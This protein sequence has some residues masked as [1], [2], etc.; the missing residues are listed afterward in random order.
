MFSYS[1]I[2]NGF[3]SGL[4]LAVLTTSSAAAEKES[5][6]N[7]CEWGCQGW[8][9]PS[10]DEIFSRSVV[11]SPTLHYS[12]SVNFKENN[13]SYTI[14]VNLPGIEKKYISITL[15]NNVLVIAAQRQETEETKDKTAHKTQRSYSFYRQSIVLPENAN[16]HKIEATH[17]NGVV[18]ITIPKT[19]KKTAKKILIH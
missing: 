12:S 16:I 13:K 4:L 6:P 3:L 14:N 19:G 9:F 2:T 17:K 5:V 10:F 18:M 1:K 8:W 11:V 15:V 7:E